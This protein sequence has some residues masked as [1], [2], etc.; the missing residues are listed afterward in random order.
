MEDRGL[1]DQALSTPD[2]EDV[3]SDPAYQAPEDSSS[4]SDEAAFSSTPGSSAPPTSRAMPERLQRPTI[5]LDATSDAA[6]AA[7]NASPVSG[8]RNISTTSSSCSSSSCGSFEAPI[9]LVR[10][11]PVLMHVEPGSSALFHTRTIYAAIHSTTTT[12]VLAR[13][14]KVDDEFM[15]A[16]AAACQIIDI[17]MLGA[18]EELDLD[19]DAIESEGSLMLRYKND[20][21]VLQGVGIGRQHDMQTP[22]TS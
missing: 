14:Q 17:G 15:K 19:T 16:R 4:V 21:V 9:L 5:T 22:N 20:V 2:E 12:T 18:G 8:R 11:E 3:V 6:A 13:W 7:E 1:Q 10:G